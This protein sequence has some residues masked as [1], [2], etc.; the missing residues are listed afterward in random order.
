MTKYMGINIEGNLN[1]IVPEFSMAEE[2]FRLVDS[3]RDHLRTFLSFVDDS[4]DVTS[5]MNY[6]KM[7]MAG[8][9]NGT[10]KIFL[11]A[12]DDKIIGSI[13]LHHIDSNN[14][15]GEIGYWIHSSYAGKNIISKAVK[16][17]CAYSFEVL[18]LN[19]LTIFAD[20]EN[21]PSNK[22]A[23]KTG[24]Q[25]V[26]TKRQDIIMYD[27]YRDMNEYYLLKSDFLQ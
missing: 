8:A 15:K 5:Q 25:L 21:I 9:A 4:V 1:L 12:S 18:K 17:L 6:F 14:G 26:G 10:D 13:D 23:L 2:L 20:V 22:V 19:K 11:I 24:F 7:K 27:Q 3:D 16:T